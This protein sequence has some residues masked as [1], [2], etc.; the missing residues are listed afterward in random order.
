MVGLPAKS[1][2]WCAREGLLRTALKVALMII[3]PIAAARSDIATDGPQPLS[4][5]FTSSTTSANPDQAV[6]FTFS[7]TGAGLIGVI[8]DFND[9]TV[10]EVQGLG[11]RSMEGT[12]S[13]AWE[14]QGRYVVTATLQDAS[15]GTVMRT[16]IIEVVAP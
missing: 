2:R 15:L 1:S 14:A 12:R 5:E 11:A 8:L 13:H 4:L 10:E 3:A 7:A 6:L 16:I 9:D